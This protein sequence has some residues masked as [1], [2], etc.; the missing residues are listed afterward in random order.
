MRLFSRL[1]GTS[2]VQRQLE[3]LY[4][5]MFKMMGMTSA[6][7]KSAFH[8]LYRQAESEAKAEGSNL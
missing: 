7:A 6:Q 2:D 4:V 5:P 1:F 8:N 3:S